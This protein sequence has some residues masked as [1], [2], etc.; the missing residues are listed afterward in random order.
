VLILQLNRTK[1]ESATG[2]QEKMLHPVPVH[3]KL[4]PQRFLMRNR[5]DVE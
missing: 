3:E 4:Y 1:F 5:A 2:K